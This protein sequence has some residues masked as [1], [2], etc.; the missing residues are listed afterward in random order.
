MK[1][2][3]YNDERISIN[4]INKFFSTDTNQITALK[5]ISIS[6]GNGE[7][8]C[9]V[10]PSG[11]GKT[12]LLRILAGL[13]SPS[14]GETIIHPTQNNSPINSMVFQEQSIFPWMTVQDTQIVYYLCIFIINIYLS[15]HPQKPYNC[16]A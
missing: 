9:I 14:S 12:T 4:N 5:D 1:I 16:Q 11:C 3:I 13:E 6:I 15:N 2:V 7:F 10:G 8:F